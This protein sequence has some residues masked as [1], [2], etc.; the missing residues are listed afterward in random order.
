MG[1]EASVL[2]NGGNY[3]EKV[4]IDVIM[5]IFHPPNEFPVSTSLTSAD[6]S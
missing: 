1:F 4:V 2:E 6:N 5:K 3:V